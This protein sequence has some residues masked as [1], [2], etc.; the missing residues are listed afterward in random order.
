MPSNAS[1][2]LAITEILTR[3]EKLFIISSL[4]LQKNLWI[5]P[6]GM[7]ETNQAAQF[8]NKSAFK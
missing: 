4:T 5:I 7:S 1:P 3:K 6:F 2:H 8:T